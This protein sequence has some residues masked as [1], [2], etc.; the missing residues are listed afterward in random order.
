MITLSATIDGI[1]WTA[2]ISSGGEVQIYRA[3]QL[4]DRGYDDGEVIHH[5]KRTPEAVLEALEAA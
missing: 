5:T 4:F 3:G 2:C 1:T